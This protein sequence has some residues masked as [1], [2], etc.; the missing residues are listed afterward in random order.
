MSNPFQDLAAS[1]LDLP[2][3]MTLGFAGLGWG[4]AQYPFRKVFGDSENPFADSMDNTLNK[5]NMA[6][7]DWV[8][9]VTGANEDS[10]LRNWGADIPA[11]ILTGGLFASARAADK[12]AKGARLVEK[13]KA[14]N[15]PNLIAKGQKQIDKFSNMTPAQL[16]RHYM[17]NDVGL[18]AASAIPTTMLSDESSGADRAMAAV[19]GLWL[20]NK[21]L[22]KMKGYKTKTDLTP[23][24]TEE[25]I[26][27]REEDM[28]ASI[29][30]ANRRM[31][32]DATGGALDKMESAGMIDPKFAT[33]LS[34]SAEDRLGNSGLVN[35]D[36]KTAIDNVKKSELNNSVFAKNNEFGG[37]NAIMGSRVGGLR[38]MIAKGDPGDLAMLGIMPDEAEKLLSDI[39]RSKDVLEMFDKASPY[40]DR[41]SKQKGL[42]GISNKEIR[43]RFVVLQKELGRTHFLNPEMKALA[44][45]VNNYAYSQGLISNVELDRFNKDIDLGLYV[46]LKSDAERDV[47]ELVRSINPY[48]DLRRNFVEDGMLNTYGVDDPRNIYNVFFNKIHSELLAAERNNM[49]SYSLPMLKKRLEETRKSLKTNGKNNEVINKFLKDYDSINTFTPEDIGEFMG[50]Y[51][52]KHPKNPI[53]EEIARQKIKTKYEKKGLYELVH[54]ENGERVYSYVPKDFKYIFEQRPVNASFL[55][56]FTVG[57]NRLFTSTISGKWNLFFLPKRVWY[58]IN[59]VVPAL[60][61]E[62]AKNGIDVSSWDLLGIYFSELNKSLKVNVARTI[63]NAVKDDVFLGKVAQGSQRKFAEDIAKILDEDE[64]VWRK[65]R[66]YNITRNDV[67]GEALKNSNGSID[68][69]FY[70][71]VESNLLQ[72]AMSAY[73]WVDESSLGRFMG[74]MTDTVNDAMPRTII[75]AMKK[76]GI[77]NDI[78]VNGHITKKGNE[79]VRNITRKLADTRRRGTGETMASKFFNFI[80]DYVPYGA[81]SLQGI[82]G[83]MDYLPKDLIRNAS[84]YL[85][86]AMRVND[87]MFDTGLDVLGKIGQQLAQLP[88]NAVFDVLWKY[89][90]LPTT[91]CYAWNYGN[92]DNARYYNSLKPWERSNKFQL[93]NFLGEGVNLSI[94]LDQEW[95][96]VKNIYEVMLERTFGLGESY[97]RGNPAFSMRDQLLWSLGQDF[98]INLPVAGEAALNLAGLKT[99]LDAGTLLSGEMPVS[100]INEHKYHTVPDGLA[101]ATIS[102]TGK[103]GKILVN[104]AEDRPVMDYRYAIPFLQIQPKQKVTSDT[105]SYLNQQLRTNP[106]PELKKWSEQRKYIMN[107]I[108]FYDR[109]GVTK[110]GKVLGTK[111]QVKKMYQRQLDEITKNAY[112]SHANGSTQAQM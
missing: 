53:D 40:L 77:E 66:E 110:S 104:M 26:R 91:L 107:E 17:L 88:D 27:K 84:F 4:L 92:E 64:R 49:I 22:G 63:D 57:T 15:K 74:M 52:M 3:N 89:I 95:S 37:L 94:P 50:K 80:Q 1:A 106:T 18:L 108:N 85:D 25:A 38:E 5:W 2:V 47:D 83:K 112:E 61:V 33:A 75:A 36:V 60:K 100:R 59:E 28:A 105:V 43:D 69:S 30:R 29:S 19:G 24:T 65:V 86:R 62:L 7:N 31:N 6:Y 34:F 42:K 76:Y 71:G 9:N 70:G 16:R 67:F 23:L 68:V 82:F 90:A 48:K 21:A 45:K 96:V 58:G 55:N 93:T 78:I 14:L 99:D 79:F 111:E 56:K 13:G 98:G 81:V 97:D 8:T 12:I 20:G 11:T 46:P 102:M 109:Y 35:N 41:M 101:E 51:N 72:K 103:L 73:R 54:F 87:G 10:F 32:I 39:V 44:R